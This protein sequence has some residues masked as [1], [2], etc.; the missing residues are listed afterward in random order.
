M[1]PPE[2][3]LASN[4]PR[5]KQ[6]LRQIDLEFSVI[7]STVHEDFS[8]KLP[9]A[10]FVRHYAAE[11]ARAVAREHANALVI[12]A[13]TIVV[14]GVNILGKPA[15]R[16]DSF[17]MLSELSGR[18]HTVLTGVSLQILS[19]NIEDTFFEATRVTFQRLSADDINYYIDNYKPFD[20]AG[21]YGIQD[22]FATGIKKV[23][24]CFYNVVGFPLAAFYRHFRRLIA[25]K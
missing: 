4:S 21:S 17:R 25:A 13:D 15:D 19:E 2:I 6:L 1:M 22:W 12:G 14:H 8:L 3:I 9:P 10:E 18:T 7:P 23:D 20:K 16:A 5:R 11:K 24:G